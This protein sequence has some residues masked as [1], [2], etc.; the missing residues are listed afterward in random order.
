HPGLPPPA[1]RERGLA[2]QLIPDGPIISP[3]QAERLMSALWQQSAGATLALFL[4]S[5]GDGQLTLGAASPNPLVEEDAADM[6]ARAV[7][8]SAEPGFVLVEEIM[9]APFVG[10]RHVTPT[11]RNF[12]TD[13]LSW[14][15]DRA[16]NLHDTY[17]LLRRVPPGRIAGFG[18]A[19]RTLPGLRAATS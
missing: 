13:S 8:A 5:K 14:G 10:V 19:F 17:D 16:D 11:F 12:R 4:L 6:I 2:V 7:E 18:M 15:P 1:S 3:R 9:S